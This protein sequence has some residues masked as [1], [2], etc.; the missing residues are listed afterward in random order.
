MTRA[1]KRWAWIF[2][3]IVM[4]VTTIPYLIA[5]SHFGGQAVFS[6]SLFG[7]ED[8][9]SY[10]AKM[11]SGSEGAWLF[12]SPYTASPQTGIF[13][14]FP[15]ILLGKL[16]AGPGIHDQLVALFHMFR[17]AA[18]MLDIFATYAFLALFVKEARL[19]RLGTALAALGGGLG[20]VLVIAGQGGWLGSL[21]LDFYSPE[22]FGF[23]EIYGLPHL[24]MARALLFFALITYLNAQPA[25]EDIGR[26]QHRPSILAGIF[27][28]LASLMQPLT[29]LIGWLVI[30]VHQVVHWVRRSRV[31]RISLGEIVTEGWPVVWIYLLS[32]P[33]ILYT[34]VVSLSDPF[35]KAWTEQN[36]ILSPNP[37]HYLVAFGLV[38]VP[39]I[40]GIAAFARQDFWKGS[41]LVVWAVLFPFL[42]YF[43]YNLQR[44]LPEGIWVV[45]L[46]GVMV[47]MQGLSPR[48][49]RLALIGL[50]LTVPTTLFLLMGSIL[51]VNQASIPIY[52][53][54]AEVKAFEY[55]AAQPGQD[56][57]IL[58]SYD[59]GN[60]LPAWAPAFVVI[61][62]GPESIHLSQLREPVSRFYQE[63]MPD[64]ERLAFLREF[65]VDYVFRGPLE[66]QLGDWNPLS[67]AYLKQVYDQD[68]Y[69]IYQVDWGKTIP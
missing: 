16:A 30:G 58:A 34:A 59:T 41:L 21:P 19:R 55:L 38:I 49:K 9:N 46:A 44:R 66:V 20:W 37:L 14:F 23:L 52:R 54:A 4:A 27:L 39:A 62:H 31:E 22:T 12:R 48:P 51:A 57:V 50:S 35:M 68:G 42:A 33:V 64:E 24:A 10:I 43:P 5:Y 8:G 3:G 32:C 53:P 17:I 60:A 61:G 6:G 7:V 18:G 67:V 45:W 25:A 56:P 40:L 47:W 63:G 1:E 36:T 2:A 13:A 15:Y 28:L 69:V 26:V 29:A 11:L 65:N